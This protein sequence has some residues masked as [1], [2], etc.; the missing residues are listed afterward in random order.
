MPHPV[1]EI[2]HRIQIERGRQHGGQL[3]SRVRK[4]RG[5]PD[6]HAAQGGI[7]RRGIIHPKFREAI[8]T[9]G[10]QEQAQK[11]HQTIPCI[12][13]HDVREERD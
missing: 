11:L 6:E 9:H 8:Y 10:Y 4:E 2:W 13:A 3:S 7:A 5:G 1:I 12:Q